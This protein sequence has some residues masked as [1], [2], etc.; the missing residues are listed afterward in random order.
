MLQCAIDSGR[1]FIEW[2]RF[3]QSFYFKNSYKANQAILYI[4][5]RIALW[6]NLNIWNLNIICFETFPAEHQYTVLFETTIYYIFLLKLH[7]FGNVSL[8]IFSS[9]YV[10]KTK[11]VKHS[12]IAIAAINM[13]EVTPARLKSPFLWYWA[14]SSNNQATCQRNVIDIPTVILSSTYEKSNQLQT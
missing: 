1:D 9:T 13:F 8:N 12:C 6:W 3:E 11:S 2:R 14:R 7:G 10:L 4:I 5:L